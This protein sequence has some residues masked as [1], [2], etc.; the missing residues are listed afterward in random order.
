LRTA[1]PPGPFDLRKRADS[2][3]EA[4]LHPVALWCNITCMTNAALYLR[5]SN[6][7]TGEHLAVDRQREDCRRIA[8]ERG[9]TIAQ[10]YVDNSISASK[11]ATKRPAYDRMVTDFAAGQF[12]A[13]V[14]W[15]LDRLTRQPRQL[16]DWIDAAEER[17]LLLTTANGE[18]DLSTDGG[19]LFA[20]IKA[21]VARAEVERKSARQIRAAAQRA[22]R[23][24][25]PSGVRLTGYTLAGKVLADEAT[26][27]RSIFTRFSAGDSLKGITVWLTDQGI[28]TRHGK[29]WSPSS[30][31][32]ILTNPR[33]AGRA[34]Y[35][36]QVT[37]KPGA[38]RLIV[39]EE[40]FDA[41]QA[42]LTDPRRITNRLGTDRR[43]LG[44]G[45]YLCGV[46][47]GLLRS[48][49]G[50]RYRCPVGGHIT[51]MGESIDNYVTGVIRERLSRPDVADLLAVPDTDAAKR[52]S[53][54]IEA[55]RIRLGKIEAD[56]DADLIDGRRYAVAT[57]K[58]QAELTRAET[59]RARTA[60][61]EGLGLVLASA[62][63]AAEFDRSPLGVQRAVVAAL[64]LA[65]T[66]LPAPR[67]HK[68]DPES[69]QI[70]WRQS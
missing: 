56:Y 4:E 64:V 62:D 45:L 34:I 59:T 28:E 23:G 49:S 11:R 68:F 15:D 37:G 24:R 1:E 58:V 57:E 55:L 19:R 36:G 46:C 48:H 30:V 25:P 67:G 7:A 38:W 42:R 16:E 35:C 65:V 44:S 60:G 2:D 20:R 61:G 66:L 29:A 31:R 14:C 50:C 18:A 54:Q 9:W 26:I 13:L 33:Y 8:T 27:V 10:E 69:V 17:G 47:G 3:V 32:T 6:D 12:E 5:V 21:S 53:A 70:Q 39:D 40:V 52:L 22:D 63:P 51:R 43:H 41:V